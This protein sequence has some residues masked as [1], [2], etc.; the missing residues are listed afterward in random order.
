MKIEDAIDDFITYL[1]YERGVA[2]ATIQS[3]SEDL[4][5]FKKHLKIDDVSLLKNSDLEDMIIRLS[6]E[7]KAASTI[8]RT[9][10]T[11]RQ[12]YKF[13]QEEKI[14]VNQSS[15]VVLPKMQEHLPSVLTIEEIDSLF[16]Q[17]N[18]DK[19]DGKRDR[20]MLELMYSSGLRVSELISLEKANISLDYQYL[21]IIGKGNKQ[22]LVPIGD[23][24]RD[25]LLD[26]MENV[27]KNNVGNLTSPYVFLN[28]RGGAIS[29][30]YFWKQIKKYAENA[31]IKKVITPHTLRH[32]FATHLLEN[33]AE[34]RYV[35][36]LLGHENISTTQIYTH[37]SSERIISTYDLYVKKE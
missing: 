9:L 33:G 34:L 27:R 25:F 3:Y 26:Y 2:K 16:N 7:G 4:Q 15:N 24:A 37:V 18:L 13:L 12:F 29:R 35:Q 6:K 36:Y 20:A 14:L 1:S 32:S 30:Q 19:K 10:T 23:L 5:N 8:V 31:K 22:R 21:K 17:P 28:N 11:I